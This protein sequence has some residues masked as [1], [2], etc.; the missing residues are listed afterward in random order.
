MM[1][2]TAA[3]EVAAQLCR[4]KAGDEVRAETLLF[5]VGVSFCQNR[6]ETGVGDVSGD[7]GSGRRMH[8]AR[9]ERERKTR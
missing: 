6:G 3:L 8:R 4:L 9:A 1:N 2:G 5:A 7:E